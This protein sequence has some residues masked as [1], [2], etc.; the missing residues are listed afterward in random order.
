M[1][2]AR[3]YTAGRTLLSLDEQEAGFVTSFE[4][5][6]IAADVIEEPAGAEPFIKKHLGQLRYEDII[7]RLPLSMSS[8]VL[9]WIAASWTMA[10]Q[11]KDGSLISCDYKL[12]ATSKLDFFEGLIT[13]TTIPA[14]DASSK[15]P[16]Y[17]RLKISP[18]VISFSKASGKVGGALPKSE[19]KT[20]LPSGFKLTIDDLDCSKVSKIDPFTVTQTILFDEIGDEREVVKAPSQVVFP[21]LRVTLSESGAQ[22]WLNWHEDFVVKGNNDDSEERNGRLSFVAPNLKEEF[23]AVKLF[24]L[25]IFRIVPDKSEATKDQIRR[26]TADLYCERMELEYPRP[27]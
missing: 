2:E 8:R 7:L 3:S 21:N 19:Q 10:N 23:A 16:A 22:S 4:G 18:E 5:G 14:C 25:G 27:G 9:Q 1:P 15:E 11:R 6:A 12:D 20:L 26:V 17:L 24:N 13:E